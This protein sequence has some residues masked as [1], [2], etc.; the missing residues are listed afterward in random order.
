MLDT[1]KN[2][3][4]GGCCLGWGVASTAEYETFRILWPEELVNLGL[5]SRHDC[6]LLIGLCSV[7]VASAANTLVYVFS[8]Y[9][10]S[11]VG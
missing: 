5:D 2:G 10:P 8:E 11:L 6:D 1:C 9:R 7:E 3:L 4:L